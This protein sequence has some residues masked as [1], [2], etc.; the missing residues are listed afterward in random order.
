MHLVSS[1]TSMDKSTSLN[2]KSNIFPFLVKSSLVKLETSQRVVFT[3]MVCVICTSLHHEASILGE[4][5]HKRLPK[6]SSLNF[7][8]IPGLIFWVKNPVLNSFFT[9]PRGV[10]ARRVVN[11]I[12]APRRKSQ[13]KY[14]FLT[15][16]LTVPTYEIFREKSA[17]NSFPVLIISSM[18]CGH[19]V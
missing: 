15:L 5:Q 19:L 1:F 9:S 4:S 14:Q 2:T 8:V 18:I 13:F 11:P 6:N 7:L 3:P 16:M 12:D 17:T 10:M